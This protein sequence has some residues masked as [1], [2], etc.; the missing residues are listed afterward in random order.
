MKTRLKN[1]AFVPSDREIE[2]D[3]A[4][5]RRLLEG[6]EGPAEPHPAY[7]QNFLVRLRDRIDEEQPMRRRSW[8]PSVAWS[9]LSAATLAVLLV[10]T[11]VIPLS[12][13]RGKQ[14]VVQESPAPVAA[15]RG[16]DAPSTE[17]AELLLGTVESPRVEGT[18]LSESSTIV[19]SGEEMRMIDAIHAD[20]DEAMFEALIA[21]EF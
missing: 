16:S 9:S 10:V 5:L 15:Q 7:Y 8:V 14:S 4:E 11:G 20:D 12:L 13:N 21:A 6:V 1:D 17:M 18:T 19:L 2:R 3:V